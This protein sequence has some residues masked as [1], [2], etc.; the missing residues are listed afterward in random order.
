MLERNSGHVVTISSAAGIIGV[1]G[2]ADYSASKFAVFGFD[3]A[4]RMELRRLKSRV[5]TTVV[6]P[7]FIDTGMFRGIKTRVPL[8]F[9]VLK[10]SRAARRIVQAVLRDKPRLIMPRIAGTA[11]LLRLCHPGVLDFMADFWRISHMMDDFKGQE[12]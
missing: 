10:S 7:F 2:L 3:E 12:K 11:F 4:I 1:T 5:K 9:P 6:C 8:L